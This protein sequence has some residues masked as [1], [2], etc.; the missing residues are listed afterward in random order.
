MFKN[1]K[2]FLLS[3]N[4]KIIK[5]GTGVCLE[6]VEKNDLNKILFCFNMKYFTNLGYKKEEMDNSI[7]FT[8]DEVIINKFH[9]S[10]KVI[11]IL[12]AKDIIDSEI[13]EQ[14]Y[15]GA[16]INYS[17]YEKI[18]GK[19]PNPSTEV[20]KKYYEQDYSHYLTILNIMETS[21]LLCPIKKAYLLANDEIIDKVASLQKKESNE[22]PTVFEKAETFIKKKTKDTHS[23]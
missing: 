18:V 1:E 19:I 20:I 6:N 14:H 11:S 4:K 15:E 10:C 2:T 17:Y 21:G 22:V 12:F 5:Q 7:K 16:E 23:E 8:S 13:L 3:Q 9:K